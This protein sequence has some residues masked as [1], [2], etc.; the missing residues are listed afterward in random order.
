MTESRPVDEDAATNKKPT[1]FWK[2]DPVSTASVT[3]VVE[4]EDKKESKGIA[5]ALGLPLSLEET[6][7]FASL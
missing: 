2:A 4:W 1:T 3:K 6:P 7:A 5:A